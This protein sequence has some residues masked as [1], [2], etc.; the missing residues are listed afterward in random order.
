MFLVELKISVKIL[1]FIFHSPWQQITGRVCHHSEADE[2]KEVKSY[3]PKDRKNRCVQM[4][5]IASYRS[6]WRKKRFLGRHCINGFDKVRIWGV[7]L[8]P[9]GCICPAPF[10][11][12]H[13]LVFFDSISFGGPFFVRVDEKGKMFRYIKA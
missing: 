6:L 5:G 10:L 4:N 2:E 1:C 11:W 7:N 13:K 8:L 12:A 9:K 3:H